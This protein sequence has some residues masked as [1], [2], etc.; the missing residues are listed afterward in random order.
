[1]ISSLKKLQFTLLGYYSFG[2]F[3]FRNL[4]IPL[5]HISMSNR[6]PKTRRRRS[7]RVSRLVLLSWIKDTDEE[8]KPCT[9]IY[10]HKDGNPSTKTTR[11]VKA[12]VNT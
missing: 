1:M 11:H 8:G 9:H 5:Q 6:K 2:L 7:F 3:F 12:N 10:L 4:Y